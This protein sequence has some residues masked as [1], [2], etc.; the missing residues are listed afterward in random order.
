L[1]NQKIKKIDSNIL[2]AIIVSSAAIIAA[3]IGVIGP[4]L[5]KSCS[6]S[7]NE[8]QIQTESNPVAQPDN[9]I[10]SKSTQE[11]GQSK[12]D[13]PFVYIT[14]TGKKYHNRNCSYLKLS[15]NIEKIKLREAKVRG[16]K[17]CSRCKPPP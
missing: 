1:K 17:P 3:L 11:N 16:F 7:A 13:D 4:A 6:D 8:V 14:K 2:G 15:K 5:N 12:M 9:N 10:R